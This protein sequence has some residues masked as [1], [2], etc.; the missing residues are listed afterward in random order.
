MTLTFL[1]SLHRIHSL[2]LFWG[3]V[4]CSVSLSTHVWGS[5]LQQ[6]RAVYDKAQKLLDK[7]KVSQYFKIRDQI[8]EYP[9]TP[10]TDYR[11]FLVNIGQKTPQEV[12]TFID[13]YKNIP[14]SG[15]IRAPYIDSLAYRKH[16]KK[17]NE[18]QTVEPR[19]ETYQCHYYYALYK[20]GNRE[21]R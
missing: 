3:A 4:V 20:T 8:A 21:N 6:Q 1:K 7:G 10:Y 5:D 18:F 2:T 13:N 9:L 19:G 16:W 14:F 11:A 12:D 17:L 15:R